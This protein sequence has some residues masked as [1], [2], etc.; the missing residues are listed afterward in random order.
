MNKGAVMTTTPDDTE[1]RQGQGLDE[2]LKDPLLNEFSDFPE[3][4][5]GV[6]EE[7][8]P[9]SASQVGAAK[10]KENLMPK[11]R[12]LE[13]LKEGGYEVDLEKTIQDMFVVIKNM[14]A[15]LER[16]LEIN[17]LLEKDLKE[18]NDMNA[19]LK[20]TK[21][22][23]EGKISRMEAEIPFKRELQIEIDHLLEERNSAQLIVRDLKSKLENTQKK[24]IQYQQRLGSLAEER[25]DAIQEVDYL[26]SRLNNATQR[27]REL[28]T[29]TKALA[30]EKIAQSEKVKSLDEALNEALDE[31]YRLHKE[32]KETKEKMTEFHSA[33]ADKKLQ[34]KKSFY[35][36]TEE[37]S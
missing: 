2:K 35:K 15:Q 7:D 21:R 10:R 29:Q 37:K 20:T 9:E 18:A 12:G 24:V 23:L 14:E 34:T 27:I 36:G 22:R 32:L 26:E 3:R 13:I 6:L 1:G 31:K 33:L 5:K 17:D 25:T 16:V 8:I 4:V 19:E 28:E 11:I 30:G